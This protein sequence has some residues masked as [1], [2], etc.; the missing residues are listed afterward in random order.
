MHRNECGRFGFGFEVRDFFSGRL[1]LSLSYHG[2]VCLRRC[3][4]SF[5]TFAF[6]F[7]WS[8]KARPIRS[9]PALVLNLWVM[10]PPFWCVIF[11]TRKRDTYTPTHL[12]IWLVV[13]MLKVIFYFCI[14]CPQA[15]IFVKNEFFPSNIKYIQVSILSRQDKF[16]SI[17]FRFIFCNQYDNEPFN[18]A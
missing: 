9:P 5:F 7:A 4:V 2:F 8:E 16:F 15:A 10:Y 3:L 1:V 6:A 17:S 14:V 18:L 12:C 13:C 11:E